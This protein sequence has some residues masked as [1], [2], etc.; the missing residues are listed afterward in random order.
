MLSPETFLFESKS[1]EIANIKVA[2]QIDASH[3]IATIKLKIGQFKSS[4]FFHLLP[5][6]IKLNNLFCLT[7]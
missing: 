4:L 1:I 6:F 3:L 7:I 5:Q 2:M